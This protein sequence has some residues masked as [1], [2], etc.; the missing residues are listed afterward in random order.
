ME[1]RLVGDSADGGDGPRRVEHADAAVGAGPAG[2]DAWGSGDWVGPFR[3]PKGA[4]RDPA[5]DRPPPGNAAVLLGIAGARPADRTRDLGRSG[6]EHDLRPGSR[7][8]G[9]IR[10]H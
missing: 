10:A 7:L 4:A 3:P 2:G 8:P 1:N 5:S 9:D 6:A